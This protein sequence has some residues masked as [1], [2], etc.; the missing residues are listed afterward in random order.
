MKTI[1]EI[2]EKFDY[3]LKYTLASDKERRTDEYNLEAL[4]FTLKEPI[5]DAWNATI[6]KYRKNKVK[7]VCYLSLEFLMGRLLTN[8]LL[9][10]GMYDKVK[11]SLEQ[12][13]VDLDNVIQTEKD[14]GLGNGGLGRL[15]ACFLDSLSTLGY[16]AIGYGIRYNYGIFRREIENGYQ[17]ENTVL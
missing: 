14:A 16:P 2:K 11:K 12:S 1:N 6:Q 9:N 15:A 7:R 5:I 17:K 3:H 13:G 4:S 10:L 8:N